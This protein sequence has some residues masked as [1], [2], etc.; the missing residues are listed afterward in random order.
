[1]TRKA[2]LKPLTQ[3]SLETI[4]R[5]KWAVMNLNDKSGNLEAK[6]KTGYWGI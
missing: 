1:M 3:V 2:L 6:I 5:N 4:E